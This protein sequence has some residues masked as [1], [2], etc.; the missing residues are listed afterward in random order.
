MNSDLKL[1][2]EISENKNAISKI[3]SDSVEQMKEDYLQY[4][5]ENLSEEE[6]NNIKNN[7]YHIEHPLDDDIISKIADLKSALRDEDDDY[8]IF[9]HIDK[10]KLLWCLLIEKSI[11][12]LRFFDKREPFIGNSEK[13]PIAYGIKELYDFF[14]KYVV[15]ESLLYGGGKY[16]RDHVVHMLR[17]W[18]LGIHCML[19]KDNDAMYLN[20]LY[21]GSGLNK[22]STNVT[23]L[24]KISIWTMMALTHDL[25][26]PLEK[27]QQVIEK[28]K[29]MMKT[30]IA[31]PI[32]SLDLS[33]NGVQNNMNDFVLRFISSKM[34]RLNSKCPKE[35]EESDHNNRSKYVARLQPKYYFKFQKSLERC[36]HGTISALVIYKLLIYFLESDFNINEDYQFDEED[37]RQFYI[38]REI[39]RSIAS[40][41]CTDVY[42]LDMCNFAFFLIIMDDSQDWGRKRISELYVKSKVKYDFGDIVTNFDD[43]NGIYQCSI[44]ETFTFPRNNKSEIEDLLHRLKSQYKNY[45]TIFRDGQDTSIRNFDFIKECKIVTDEEDKP[46]FNVKLN[47]PSKKSSNIMIELSTD[48]SAKLKTVSK[49]YNESYFKSQNIFGEKAIITSRHLQDKVVFTIDL[50]N[51]NE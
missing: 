3:Y 51:E 18:M 42:H 30:F 19:D 25:G 31:N 35:F 14:D 23:G 4:K 46:I 44:N 26:Y 11:K 13:H 39:L 21:I 32:L 38:R 40:H 16:Y 5:E 47:I 22:S 41:T 34:I 37:T 17:V 9:I 50:S 24:E 8:R 36:M 20:K 10:I 45:K 48:A 15:F 33:F 43:E 27:S 7:Q 28:T 49:T 6:K 2:N 1:F 29:E 12:C